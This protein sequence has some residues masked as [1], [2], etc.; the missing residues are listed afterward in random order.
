LVVQ[1]PSLDTMVTELS[2]S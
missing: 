2:R 1:R